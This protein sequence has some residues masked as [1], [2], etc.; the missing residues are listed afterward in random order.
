MSEQHKTTKQSFSWSENI[1]SPEPNQTK[2]LIHKYKI[3]SFDKIITFV[4]LTAP[5]PSVA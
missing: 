3:L 4:K 5:S 1:K 2:Y